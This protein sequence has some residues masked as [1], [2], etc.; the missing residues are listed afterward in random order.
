MSTVGDPAPQPTP[1]P[2]PAPGTILA[3]LEAMLEHQRVRGYSMQTGKYLRH[4]IERFAG[5]CEERGIMQVQ[6][7]N[8]SV[9]ESYQ[10]WLGRWRIAH[11]PHASRP[12]ALRSQHA[13]LWCVASFLRWATKAG[14]LAYNPADSLDLPRLGRPLP[15]PALTAAE[16]ER[17]VAVPEVTNPEGLRD[18]AM[19]EVLY[20][21]GLRRG[22]L[23]ALKLD[24]IDQGRALVQVRHGKGNRDRMVPISR[25]AL[26]WVARY[27]VEARP[28]LARQPDDGVVFLMS[29]GRKRGVPFSLNRLTALMGSY[30]AAAGIRKAGAC[31]IF[32]HTAATLMMEHGADP[33][34]IQDFLGHAQIQTTGIYTHVTLKHLQEVHGRTHP[35]ALSEADPAGSPPHG[36]E[37]P[38]P[39]PG[40]PLPPLRPAEPPLPG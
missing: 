39:P 32:R 38:G 18:R 33:R 13:L 1:R 11:G 35:S 14:H 25:R 29:R 3:V 28:L 4:A 6:E 37:P 31:H 9:I 16:V 19:L 7:V 10:R 20:A 27:V 40:R 17:I 5:Y 22:E 36:A 15:M 24:D 30:V 8:R 26:D 12:L 34:V 2:T 23:A 21:T